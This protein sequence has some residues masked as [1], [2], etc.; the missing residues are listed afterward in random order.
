[1]CIDLLK[2]AL[3]LSTEYIYSICIKNHEKKRGKVEIPTFDVD[4][5]VKK[6]RILDISMARQVKNAVIS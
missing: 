2:K 1:M 6:V 3:K 5:K 4:I